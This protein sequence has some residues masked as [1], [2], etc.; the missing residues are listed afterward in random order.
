M[1]PTEWASEM[2][3]MRDMTSYLANIPKKDIVGMRTPYLQSGGDEMYTMMQNE[4]FLYDCSAP[5]QVFFNY[6]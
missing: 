5:S 1:T 4:D 6:F 3:G 2:G